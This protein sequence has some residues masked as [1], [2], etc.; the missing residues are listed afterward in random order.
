M[1][2]EESRSNCV[3][4][5]SSPEKTR[6]PWATL[7]RVPRQSGHCEAM[8]LHPLR[9]CDGMPQEWGFACERGIGGA[10]RPGKRALIHE[11]AGQRHA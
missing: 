5:F 1:F 2:S 10:F 3:C 11:L 9:L 7:R 4:V 6:A 8:R